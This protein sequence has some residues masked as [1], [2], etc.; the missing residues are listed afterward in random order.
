MLRGMDAPLL[1]AVISP[2]A[3]LSLAA[4][5][6]D[7][8]AVARALVDGANP[9]ARL[10][11]DGSILF[12]ACRRGDLA[13]AKLLLAAG[14]DPNAKEP[15]FASCLHYCAC[16]G[17]PELC[18]ALLLAGA[19]PSSLNEQGR[20]PLMEACEA[21][22]TRAIEPE[23]ARAAAA[24]AAGGSAFQTLDPRGLTALM[25]ACL[26]GN[27]CSARALLEAG[28]PPDDRAGPALSRATA[29]RMLSRRLALDPRPDDEEAAILLLDFGADPSLRDSEGE[30]SR[31]WLLLA[32]GE[33]LRVAFEAAELRQL[34]PPGSS[35]SEGSSSL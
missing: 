13:C 28:A 3:E 6:S 5:A 17:E 30:S 4:I 23:R 35:R 16:S 12:Q 21:S 9:N 15:I 32:R 26:C 19:D 18:E 2:E 11:R 8:E 33:R 24:L 31:D 14:A 22:Y 29:L 20:T 34:M 27:L 1:P 10:N 25:I 7:L